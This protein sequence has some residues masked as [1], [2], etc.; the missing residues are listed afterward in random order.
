M[1]PTLYICSCHAVHVCWLIENPG[2]T[3]YTK[4]VCTKINGNFFSIRIEN[5]TPDVLEFTRP[6]PSIVDDYLMSIS[7]LACVYYTRPNSF[8]E[9]LGQGYLSLELSAIQKDNPNSVSSEGIAC[10]EDY[11]RACMASVWQMN[12]WTQTT[13]DHAGTF[14]T[15]CISKKSHCTNKS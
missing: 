6:F 11:R 9:K 8:Y 13:N 4:A 1:V 10:L 5:P 12:I 3:I 15:L 7:K 14:A 2:L